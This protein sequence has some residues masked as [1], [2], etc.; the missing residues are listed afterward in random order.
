MQE[1][2]KLFADYSTN[3]VIVILFIWDWVKNR[4]LIVTTLQEMATTNSNIEKCLSNMT[5]NEDN[6]TKS[7]ELLQKS[8]EAQ[9]W[10]LNKLLER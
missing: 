1:I 9:D 4:K 10:K 3:M 7:L 6:M 5:Q 2:V 8:M